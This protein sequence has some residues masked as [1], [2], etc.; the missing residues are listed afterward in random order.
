MKSNSNEQGVTWTLYA[1]DAHSRPYND[2]GNFF[3][4]AEFLKSVKLFTSFPWKS[5]FSH[6]K[7]IFKIA[8]KTPI[9]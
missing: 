6:E 3:K 8:E 9:L 2:N 5:N 1:P 7:P 4:I